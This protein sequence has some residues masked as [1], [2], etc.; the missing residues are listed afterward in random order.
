[1]IMINNH[2]KIDSDGS[3]VVRISNCRKLVAI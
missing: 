2:N 1:M 3:T